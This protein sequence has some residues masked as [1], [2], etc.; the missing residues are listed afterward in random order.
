MSSIERETWTWHRMVPA[1]T[2]VL[3]EMVR[4]GYGTVFIQ[5]P[6]YSG[7]KELLIK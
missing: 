6:N 5:L 2:P 4:T 1:Q 7:M 3:L